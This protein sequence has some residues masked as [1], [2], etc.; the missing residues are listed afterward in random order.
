MLSSV[1]SRWACVTT[2]SLFSTTHTH[3]SLPQD[4]AAT[5]A[6]P[7]ACLAEAAATKTMFKWP[8]AA[9]AQQVDVVFFSQAP[10]SF[11]DTMSLATV[12]ADLVANS[13]EAQHVELRE[14]ALRALRC[15]ASPAE[16]KLAALHLLVPLMKDAGMSS[17]R[18]KANIKTTQKRRTSRSRQ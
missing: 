13:A 9:E 8:P 4:A 7:L 16:L 18:S 11:L 3:T 2:L 14:A 17:Q 12:V 15:P 10:S 1:G 5:A 6:A